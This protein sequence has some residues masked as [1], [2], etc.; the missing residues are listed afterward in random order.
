MNTQTQNALAI[1]SDGFDA[2][3]KDPTASP[4]KGGNRRFKDAAYFEFSDRIDV[5][6]KGYAVVGKESGWQKLEAGCA[7]EYL[8]RI[9]GEP[10]QARPEVAEADWPK[11][12]NGNPEHPW[13]WTTYLHLIDVETGE[14]STFSTSTIGGN[15]AIGELADQIAFMRK[16]RP[17][18][19]PVVALESR[20]MPTQF[21]GTKPRPYFRILGWR[22]RGE[23]GSQ[24][25]L[26]YEPAPESSSSNDFND[27]LPDDLAPPKSKGKRS[28][29]EAA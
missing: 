16:T 22:G 26:T 5:A 11:N 15:I 29:S 6:G 9:P 20:D 23:A 27:S 2:D 17:D 18:A 7:P 4:I 13:K 28:K 1:Y 14:V 24:N 12:F 3:A 10:K 25:L 19:V 8:M 21:G